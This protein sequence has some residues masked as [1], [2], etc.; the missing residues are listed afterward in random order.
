MPGAAPLTSVTDALANPASASPARSLEALSALLA[1]TS[2][3][4]TDS[5]RVVRGRGALHTVDAS[6]SR[7]AL[8]I[9]I[10]MRFSR[11]MTTVLSAAA[12]CLGA[13]ACGTTAASAGGAYST[14]PAAPASTA[15]APA[16]SAPASS[17]NATLTVRKTSIGYVL[18]TKTGQTIYWYSTD[19]KNSGKSACTGSCLTAWPAVTGTPTPA[20][21]VQL[22]G[23][24]GTITRPGGVV[25]ATYNGYPL[26]TYAAD[27][28]PGQTTG[29]G[30]GGVWHV[31][32]GAVLSASPATDAA[33]SLRDGSGSSAATPSSAPSATSNGGGG[34]GY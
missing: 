10:H 5:L 28:S 6:F 33:A 29:N 21:G 34:Y 25:Q 7:A 14:T 30:S 3:G 8:A 18:A 26:Y 4:I 2:R 22:A 20:P 27:M 17:A 9:G 24:L 32:T 23:K 15:A 11:P 19:V 31:I 16:S 12:L 1:A 13:A